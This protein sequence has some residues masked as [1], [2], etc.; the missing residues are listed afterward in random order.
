M[1]AGGTLLLLPGIMPQSLSDNTGVPGAEARYVFVYGTLRRGGSNDI[2]R[3]QPAPRYIA[4]AG[5]MGVL[6]HLGHYPGV[7]LGGTCPV[8]GE[9]YGI[10]PELERRLDEIEQILPEPTGEYDKREMLIE[11]AREELAEGLNDM[12]PGAAAV[13]LRCIVYEIN[14][15]RIIGRASIESG[16][17]IKSTAPPALV[18]AARP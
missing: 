13:R 7:Q 3:L 6:Y 12:A 1:R 2:T 16:D 15:D 18:E 8:W 10:S 9:I 14:P 4:R 17:W 5:V 11:V